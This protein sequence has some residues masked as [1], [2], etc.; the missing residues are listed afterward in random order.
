MVMAYLSWG[1]SIIHSL[2]ETS[3][4]LAWPFYFYL[5]GNNFKVK[6]VE[7]IIIIYGL[8]YVVLFFFQYA[9][10]GMV[11]FGKPLYGDEWSEDRGVIRIIFPGAGIF[12]LAVFIALTKVTTTKT[13]VWFWVLILILG[14]VIPIM[15]VTRQ[16]IAGMLLVYLYHFMA[17]GKPIIKYALIFVVF[18]VGSILVNLEIDSIK[19]VLEAGKNDAKLGKNYIRVLAAKYFLE[20]YAPNDASK[21]FGSGAPYWGIS[22]VGKFNERLA[23]EKGYFLSDVGIIAVYAMFGVFAVLGFVII[24]VKSFTIK[25]SESFSYAKYYLWYILFTSVTW[26]SVYYYHYIISTILALYLFQK[27][28]EHEEK[29]KLLKKISTKMK[30]KITEY[31]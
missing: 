18:L 5:V 26:Y 28:I 24:W 14:I 1:Q 11:L 16:F 10:Q 7:R 15:Q 19:G 13:Y 17:N 20:D 3:Q 2:L 23:D 8:L 29:K 27:G 31:I 25:L 21:I 12:I 22:S 4:Y 9:N 30:L 6:T